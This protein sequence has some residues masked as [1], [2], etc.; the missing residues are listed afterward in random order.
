MIPYGK[1]FIDKDDIDNISKTLKGNFLTTGPL[2]E[3][4]ENKINSFSIPNIQLFVI[5]LR[6]YI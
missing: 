6:L 4:F 2:V 1:Q 5:V 3:K